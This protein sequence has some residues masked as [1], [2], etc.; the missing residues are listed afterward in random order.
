MKNLK[1]SILNSR[2]FSILW[3][4]YYRY[5][6]IGKNSTLE[7]YGNELCGWSVNTE[8]LNKDSIVYSVGV[9]KDITFDLELYNRFQCKIYLF[10][11]TP[12][13]KDWIKDQNLPENAVFLDYGIY[14]KNSS[15]EFFP[16][17]NVN[18]ISHSIIQSNDF[19]VSQG[20]NVTVKTLKD[21]IES[22]DHERID[23]LKLDIEGAEYVI[24]KTIITD[25]IPIKQIIVEF[26]H[27]FSA[28]SYSDTRQA[29][30]LLT[31]EG[32]E[33]ISISD[34]GNQIAFFKSDL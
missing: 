18:Y 17:K 19:D 30:R 2:I 5:G 4:N 24:L 28:F 16:P 12:E 25:Q 14:D 10:D 22:F 33:L 8:N 34:N 7:Y 1:E 11:P 13:V 6:Y 23:L 31:Q 26:H 32:Y 9:G 27:R 3:K 15:I 21:V 20:F 29:I